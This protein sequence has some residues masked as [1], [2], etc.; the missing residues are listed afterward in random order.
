MMEAQL[1]QLRNPIYYSCR[2]TFQAHSYLT[3][4]LYNQPS[5]LTPLAQA[6]VS[7]T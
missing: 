5:D 2:N 1:K 7:H 4:K 3:Q 6:A